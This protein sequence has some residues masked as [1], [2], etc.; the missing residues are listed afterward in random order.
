MI[1]EQKI[2]AID[3]YNLLSSDQKELLIHY[4]ALKPF[5]R[6]TANYYSRMAPKILTEEIIRYV[7]EE[8]GK[9]FLGY[10]FNYFDPSLT[11]EGSDYWANILAKESL[12]GNKALI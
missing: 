2:Y 5:C 12:F 7:L 6:A 4:G 9:K 8:E 3:V 10:I 11:V 1:P